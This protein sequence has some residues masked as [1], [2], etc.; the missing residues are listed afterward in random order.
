[1]TELF[2]EYIKFNDFNDVFFVMPKQS[3]EK[4]P[5]LL[6]RPEIDKRRVILTPNTGNTV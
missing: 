4:T 3:G 1:M 2:W 6:K 5:G